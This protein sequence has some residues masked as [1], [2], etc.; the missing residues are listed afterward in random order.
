MMSFMISNQIYKMVVSQ[1]EHAFYWIHF[2]LKNNIKIL[3]D[4]ETPI[5]FTIYS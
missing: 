5:A 1:S 2:L 3:I 4:K